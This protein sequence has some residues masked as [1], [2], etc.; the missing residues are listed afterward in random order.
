MDNNSGMGFNYGGC[1][2]DQGV[3]IFPRWHR[4]VTLHYEG[5]HPKCKNVLHLAASEKGSALM[6]VG[7]VKNEQFNQTLHDV[8]CLGFVYDLAEE[9]DQGPQEEIMPADFAIFAPCWM[10]G[11]DKENPLDDCADVD[12]DCDGV[13]GPG[14]LNFFATAWQK[15][16]CDSN[17]VVPACQLHCDTAATGSGE[18]TLTNRGDYLQWASPETIRSFGLPVPPRDW[19]GWALDPSQDRAKTRRSG[20][21]GTR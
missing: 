5:N 12:W 2:L 14:D 1:T 3:G 7:E 16:V 18:G 15:G 9:N 17:I 8:E 13:I 6:E 20:R 4:L 19:A 11:T 10:A 21:L